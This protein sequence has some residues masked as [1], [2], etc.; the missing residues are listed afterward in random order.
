MRLDSSILYRVY[1]RGWIL[2]N[3]LVECVNFYFGQDDG[4]FVRVRGVGFEREP[5]APSCKILNVTKRLIDGRTRC[6]GWE[7]SDVCVFSAAIFPPVVVLNTSVQV[8]RIVQGK[9]EYGGKHAS[10]SS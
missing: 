10:A 9:L 5:T 1:F 8:V 2:K 6:R 7:G 4:V 3:W